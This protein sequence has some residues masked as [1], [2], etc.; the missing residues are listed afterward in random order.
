VSAGI[1]I[2]RISTLESIERD[3]FDTTVVTKDTGYVPRID[4]QEYLK[5][6]LSK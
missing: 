1:E 6:I 3:L 5:R 4:F 2:P